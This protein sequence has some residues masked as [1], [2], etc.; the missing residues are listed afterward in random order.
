MG[1]IRLTTPPTDTSGFVP[2][3]GA[4]GDVDLGEFSIAARSNVFTQ[5]TAEAG[6]DI[7]TWIN[8]EGFEAFVVTDLDG[9]YAA[10]KNNDPNSAAFGID[11]LHSTTD[12]A[13]NAA[14]GAGALRALTTGTEN[15]AI[16]Y[17]TLRNLTT[18][19]YN[20]AAG[21]RAGFIAT[22][23]YQN[24]LVG[25][26]V[27]VQLTTGFRNTILGDSGGRTLTTGSYNV[28]N[29]YNTLFDADAVGN[30]ML[31]AEQTSTFDHCVVLGRGA[32]SS[33]A[34]QFVVGSATVNAGAVTTEVVASNTSWTVR[35]NG[36]NYKILMQAI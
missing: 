18:G 31:G 36:A 2:Y 13:L 23:S 29:G 30:S 24:V 5:A 20:V 32:T 35:I 1:A 11:A 12:A 6:N 34:N 21:R 25:S 3:T 7:G 22:E 33:A 19:F 28:V 26:D 10:G 27:A 16:G 15:T 17:Q 14:F 4:T 9:V 8:S